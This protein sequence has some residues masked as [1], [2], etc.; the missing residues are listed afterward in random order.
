MCFT[1]YQNLYEDT[2][3]D[4]VNSECFPLEIFAIYTLCVI[5]LNDFPLSKYCKYNV[6]YAG[7]MGQ[8]MYIATKQL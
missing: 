8:N 3:R 4:H 1:K 5:I 2:F 7:C 6:I